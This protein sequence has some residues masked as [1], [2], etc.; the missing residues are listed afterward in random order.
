[1]TDTVKLVALLD[2]AMKDLLDMTTEENV[3]F[4]EDKAEEV[5]TASA[6]ESVLGPLDPNMPSSSQSSDLDGQLQGKTSHDG[7]VT[8]S[9]SQQP[10]CPVSKKRILLER[11][12][13]SVKPDSADNSVR[14]EVMMYVVLKQSMFCSEEDPDP[15][16]FWKKA[17]GNYPALA[18]LAR[19]VFSIVPSSVAVES[20]FS[21]SGLVLNS[22]RSS[23]APYRM[24][25]IL[26]IHDNF[27]SFD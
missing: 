11:F 5:E 15:L 27:K 2:P 12:R 16:V 9:L 14:G 24:N 19:R 8:E 21:T 7:T 10:V 18:K 22:K 25:Y 3:S 13:A 1:M 20:M 17:S 26:F 4:L 6:N 23:L